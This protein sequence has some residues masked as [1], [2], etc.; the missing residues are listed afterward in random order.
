M[1]LLSNYSI[2]TADIKQNINSVKI[3]QI[4]NSVDI[5]VV[6]IKEVYYFLQA[7]YPTPF[8]EEVENG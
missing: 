1:I 7:Q 6:D 2:N 3:D 5:E 4:I 8:I